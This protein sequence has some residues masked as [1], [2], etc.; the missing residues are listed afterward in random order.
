M[1]PKHMENYEGIECMFSIKTNTRHMLCQSPFG[2]HTS[3]V[4]D[5]RKIKINKKLTPSRIN[6]YMVNSLITII[7]FVRAT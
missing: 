1:I 6:N 3:C 4:I 2:D 7:Q 5:G